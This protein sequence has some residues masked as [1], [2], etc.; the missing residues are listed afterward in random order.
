MAKTAAPRPAGRG[1]GGASAPSSNEK[2]RPPRTPSKS[3]NAAIDKERS[4]ERKR[5]LSEDLSRIRTNRRADP[6]GELLPVPGARILTVLA[7]LP[8]EIDETDHATI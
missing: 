7:A 5:R 3:E 4:R 6:I 2:I 8:C 1:R